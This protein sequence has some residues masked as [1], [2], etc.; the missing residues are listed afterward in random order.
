MLVRM[1]PEQAIFIDKL[2]KTTRSE[3]IVFEVDTI[4]QIILTTHDMSQMTVIKLESG[5]FE[6]FQ[7]R[8]RL[9]VS[10][11]MKK[12]Y[13]QN[14]KE[15]IFEITEDKIKFEYRFSGITTRRNYYC[16][17]PDI[18]DID[19][20]Q[21]YTLDLDLARLRRVL[22]GIKDK[23]IKI[24]IDD[25]IFF[26]GKT[27]SITIPGTYF[28][29]EFEIEAEKFK[30]VLSVADLFYEHKITLPVDFSPVNFTYRMPDVLFTTFISTE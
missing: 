25:Q 28:E 9:I 16:L 18:F 26:Y 27:T 30:S 12:F 15:L 22:A 8:E 14:M 6:E 21:K 3:Y 2:L 13:E 20:E 10:T 4:L 24:K 5:F 23:N 29:A 19:F 11:Q 17:H 1:K 7:N